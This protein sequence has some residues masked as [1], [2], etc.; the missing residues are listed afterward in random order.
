VD[1]LSSLR[2][3]WEGALLRLPGIVGVGLGHD[4]AGRACLKLYVSCPADKVRAELPPELADEPLDI[5]EVG[6]IDAQN[7]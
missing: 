4:D 1:R 5:V 2:Q 6:R 3:R 7:G